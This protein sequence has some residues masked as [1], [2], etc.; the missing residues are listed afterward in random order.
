[1]YSVV[2]WFL[3]LSIIIVNI[4]DVFA[5]V[6]VNSLLLLDSIPLHGHTSVF[7]QVNNR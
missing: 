3:S 6:S 1:M 7:Y 4:I 2:V 5:R